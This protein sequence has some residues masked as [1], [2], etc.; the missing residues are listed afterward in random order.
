MNSNDIYGKH[1]KNKKNKETIFIRLP[2]EL[3]KWVE[4]EA[5]KLGLT[6]PGFVKLRLNMIKDNKK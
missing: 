4:K 6:V 5:D 3:K 2:T 1:M